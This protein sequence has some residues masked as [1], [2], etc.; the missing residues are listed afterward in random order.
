LATRCAVGIDVAQRRA[1]SVSMIG[2]L[3]S[4]PRADASLT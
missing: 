2:R 1:P 4:R 3:I